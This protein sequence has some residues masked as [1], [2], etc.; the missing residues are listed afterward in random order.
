MTRTCKRGRFG[1]ERGASVNPVVT[2]RRT[3]GGARPRPAIDVDGVLPA[4]SEP[5]VVA[6]YGLPYAQGAGRQHRPARP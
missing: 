2:R 5:A 6:R 4:E 1:Q 3:G